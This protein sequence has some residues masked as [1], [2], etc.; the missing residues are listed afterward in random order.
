MKNQKLNQIKIENIN[1][2]NFSLHYLKPTIYVGE[3]LSTHHDNNN[4]K[5]KRRQF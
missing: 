5:K 3:I 2:F 4:N 1:I